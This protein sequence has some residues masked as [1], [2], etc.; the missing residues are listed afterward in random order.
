MTGDLD[1]CL[2]RTIPRDTE[3]LRLLTSYAGLVNEIDAMS[4]P[5]MR[6]LIATHFH[7]LISL[8]LGA[9]RDA[10]QTAMGR[11]VRAARLRA[12]KNDILANLG[13]AD[14]SI[15]AVARRHGITPRYLGMLF[16]GE[17]TSFSQFVL[18]SRL[19]RAHRV[20]RDPRYLERPVSAIAFACGFGDLSYFNR[21]FRRRYAAT[22]SDVRA[23]RAACHQNGSE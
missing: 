3:A 6:S 19:E 4:R 20:L 11:G 1:A 23:S 21:A 12:I 16:A 14:L 8:T 5:E 17:Q 15:D 22:P 13:H 9:T 18:A 10:V 7:D 2:V